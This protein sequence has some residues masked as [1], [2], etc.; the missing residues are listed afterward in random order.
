MVEIPWTMRKRERLWHAGVATRTAWLIGFVLLFAGLPM[1][2]DKWVYD[3]FYRANLYDQDWARML[4]L[5]GFLPMWIVAA[6]AIWLQGR[7]VDRPRAKLRAW[8][9]V[10][11]PT[12]AGLGAEILKLLLRRERP[13]V[14]AGFYSFRQWSEQPFSTAGLALPSSHTMVAFGAATALGQLYPRARW[15]W[16]ALAVGCGVTRV[17]SRAHFLS[18]AMFGALMGWCVGW[19]VWFVMKKR[20]EI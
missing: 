9:M 10:I 13:E 1:L 17:L 18:D 20:G 2:A 16:Y 3:H 8:Y 19:G 4:R 11:A 12:A 15:V 14:N 7:E 5:M 6:V